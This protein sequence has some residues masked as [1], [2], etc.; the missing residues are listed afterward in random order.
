MSKVTSPAAVGSVRLDPVRALQHTLYRAAKAD[1]GRRFHTLWDKIYRRDVLWRAWVL[2]F[3]N[4][5]APGIDKITLADVQ[6]YGPTRL[7]DELATELKNG[8]YRPLPARRVLIPKAGESAEMRPLSIPSVRDRIVQ[9]ACKIVL[10]PVFEADMLP[11]SFGFR[12]KRGAHDALQVLI[13]ESWRG[14]RWVVETDI[15][16]CFSAIPHEGLMHAIEE[17]VCDQSVLKLLRVMLRA[18]VMEDG[19]VR[20]EVTGTPQGGVISPLLCNVYLHRIDRA[21]NVREHGV[22]VRFAD[23]VLVMCRSREQAEAALARLRELLAELGLE[24]KEAK[25]R[26]VR[27]EVGGAGFDFLGFH[28]RLVRVTG[29]RNHRWSVTFLAR[30]PADRAMKH[31]RDRIRELTRRSRLLLRVEVIV[32]EV[33]R[34]LRGWAAYFRYG[35]SAVRFE[36]I[37]HHVWTRIALVIAKRHKRSR[38]YGWSVL[39]YQSPDHFGLIS[40]SGTVVAP[41]P[42]K[43]WRGKPNAGGERRR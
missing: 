29:R 37:M 32:D 21:W 30:W 40:L 35:N 26:I 43:D 28:H 25:T 41:R 11:C 18:G 3:R 23:D 17:R 5:G 34:F 7:L 2:V 6:E 1:P 24:P 15:A 13:D 10:E 22:L 4:G 33:N 27:L 42:F 36:K 14:R 38:A 8:S 39:A 19:G 16:N 31:A 20:R 9:A 12:P